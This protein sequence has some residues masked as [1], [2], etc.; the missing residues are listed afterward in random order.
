MGR[1]E[2]A[3]QRQRQFHDAEV[4][5]QMPTRRRDLVDQELTD[6]AGQILQLRLRQVL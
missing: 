1:I 2:D 3:V 5:S 4:G 6:F